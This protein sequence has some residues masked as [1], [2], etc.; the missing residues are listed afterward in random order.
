MF[1]HYVNYNFFYIHLQKFYIIYEIF[2]GEAAIINENSGSEAGQFGFKCLKWI[3]TVGWAIYPIGYLYG[4][5]ETTIL[6]IT[7][8][9][10][11][12]SVEAINI[13]YNLADLVNKTAFGVA[14]WIAAVKD[15]KKAERTFM[16]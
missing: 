1:L 16:L 8:S 5:D 3:V 14:I 6:G 15:T 12:Y 10:T 11:A 2:K 7:I 4:L 9:N 13:I